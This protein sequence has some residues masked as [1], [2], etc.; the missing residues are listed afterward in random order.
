MICLLSLPH[1]LKLKLKLIRERGMR[2]TKC[3]RLAGNGIVRIPSTAEELSPR[4]HIWKNR[5]NRNHCINCTEGTAI[6]CVLRSYRD[7]FFVGWSSAGNTRG[8]LARPLTPLESS[9]SG[10]FAYLSLAI[11]SYLFLSPSFLYSFLHGF[12]GS[13]CPYFRPVPHR[14]RD[15]QNLKEQEA[16]PSISQNL[17]PEQIS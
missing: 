11:C 8:L 17:N 1:W 6:E 14:L 12:L 16:A 2:F 4:L 15:A 5:P 13:N 3:L 9:G 7:G 10:Y